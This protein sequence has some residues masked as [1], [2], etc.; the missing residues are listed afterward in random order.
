MLLVIIEYLYEVSQFFDREKNDKNNTL[1]LGKQ[2]CFTIVWGCAEILPNIA[3]ELFKLITTIE[4]EYITTHRRF[5]PIFCQH[6]R[7]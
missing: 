3:K 5:R 6:R 2:I 7:R 4:R 1:P